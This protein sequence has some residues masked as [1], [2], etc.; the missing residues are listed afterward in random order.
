MID[1]P[2]YLSP[3]SINTFQTCPLKFKFS[4]IDRIIDPPTEATVLGNFVHET[5]EGLFALPAEE[6]TLPNARGLM[7]KVWEDSW[8]EQ[9]ASVLRGNR[10]ALR[11]FRWKAWWCVE[12]YFAMEDPADFEP[13]GVETGLDGNIGKARIKGFIDRW[14]TN[15]DGTITI[16]DYKT[17]K[18][19][20]PQWADDKFQQLFIYATLLQT[21]TGATVSNVN[22]LYLKDSV[23]M[24]RPVTEESINEV[25]VT[26]DRVYDEVQEYCAAGEFPAIKNK[27]CNWCSYKTMCPVW[28]R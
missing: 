24:S 6:R 15:G 8:G 5:L 12:N 7:R 19:P 3:S 20:K 28:T 22:L 21:E 23:I 25:T 10:E 18:T 11:Q 13:S 14:D 27:L 16:S 9:A 2:E 4:R 26:I 17:G 1:V